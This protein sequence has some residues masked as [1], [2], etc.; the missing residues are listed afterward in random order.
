MLSALQD[1]K[2][3]DFGLY[4]AGPYASRLLADLGAQVIKLEPPEGDTL[5][6]TTKPFNA[7]QR[8]KRSIAVDLKSPNGLSIAHRIAARSDV[9]TH[10]LRP[11]VAERLGM[12]YDVIHELNPA[13]IYV[14]AP[15]WG[16]TGPDAQRTGF[17]PFYSGYVGLHHETAGDGNAPIAPPA[18]E[19]NGNGLV[20]AG[21]ILMALYHRSRTGSGQY[22]EHPQL[23]ATLLM[24]L[25]LMRR[26]DGTLIGSAGLDH[27]R[28]G[29]REHPLD[30]VYRTS[31]GWIALAVRTDRDYQRL[32]KLPNFEGLPTDVRPSTLGSE[33]VTEVRDILERR[34]R[35][36]SSA[37]WDAILSQVGV[38]CEIVAGQESIHR[39]L[40]DPEQ[41]RLGR[42]EEYSHPRWGVVRDIA[43]LIRMSSATNQP[44][45]P[46]P[47][48]GQ[49]TDEILAE[50]GYSTHEITALHDC[51]A[52]RQCR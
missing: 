37:E 10:N 47:E 17:A 44:G 31:D 52:T 33:T 30:R 19:D 50:I 27:D 16:S 21:A 41:R 2:I 15:G 42:V 4:F 32:A 29:P 22:V 43:V 18:N 20:G 36:R 7:A 26:P 34:F 39:L 38:P 40:H 46:A 13:I 45:R 8:N 11:G 28:L 51:G 24:A 3:L 12:G 35:T 25:H 9:V 23:N 6:P 48:I 14:H 1:V 5:R 49:H